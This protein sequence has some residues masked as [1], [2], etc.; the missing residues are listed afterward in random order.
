MNIKSTLNKA[1]K[2]LINTIL[3]ANKAYLTTIVENV[4]YNRF[5]EAID[6]ESL[7]DKTGWF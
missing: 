3:L 6:I 5:K 2:K 7:T 4:D 1:L